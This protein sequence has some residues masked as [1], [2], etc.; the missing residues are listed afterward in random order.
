[1]GIKKSIMGIKK[2]IKQKIKNLA[3][4]FTFLQ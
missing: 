4:P 1:M 2:S 3:E